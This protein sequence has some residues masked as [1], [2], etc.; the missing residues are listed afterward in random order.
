[1]GRGGSKGRAGVAKPPVEKNHHLMTGF[2]MNWRYTE[3]QAVP[4]CLRLQDKAF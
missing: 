4:V 3:R 1:M 2:L